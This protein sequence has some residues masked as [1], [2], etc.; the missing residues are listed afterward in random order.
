MI[1]R[2]AFGAQGGNSTLMMTWIGIAVSVVLISTTQPPWCNNLPFHTGSPSSMQSI[3][4]WKADLGNLHT[5][6][7]VPRYVMG[8]S[9]S[10]HRKMLVA[11]EI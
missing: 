4:D 10:W 9:T 3:N 7:G 1:L 6:S 5:Y 8:R 2:M 11:K